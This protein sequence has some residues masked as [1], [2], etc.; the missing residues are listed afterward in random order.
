MADDDDLT[1]GPLSQRLAHSKWK[2]R[3]IAYE[4]LTALFSQAE[5]DTAPVF[6][7]YGI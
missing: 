1:S 2:A 7:E 6:R 5:E 3:Q 4:E